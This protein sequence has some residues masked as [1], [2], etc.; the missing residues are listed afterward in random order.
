MS[1]IHEESI[2]KF[3]AIYYLIEHLASSYTG[4]TVDEIA[5]ETGKS[6]K[7]ST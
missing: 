2:G 6:E 3:D 1:Y 7:N 5:Y 4:M